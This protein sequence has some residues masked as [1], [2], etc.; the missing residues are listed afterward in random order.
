MSKFLF[1]ANGV[2]GQLSVY[3][4]KVVISRKGLLGTLTHGLKGDK[5]IRISQIS[6]I[7]FKKANMLV[8]GYIQ[9]AFLGGQEA[10]GG[11]YQATQ[12]ENTIMFNM[13]QQKDFEHAKK[14]IEEQMNKLSAQTNNVA[15]DIPDQIKKLAELKEAGILTEKEFEEKKAELLA[16]L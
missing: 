14:L 11:I 15:I 9:F 16:K 2:G 3:D 10:K 8:N 7:Q 13:S 1:Q 6:S 5:E 12:D 4:D